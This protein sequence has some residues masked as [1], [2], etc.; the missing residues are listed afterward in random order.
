MFHCRDDDE[1][2]CHKAVIS[3]C[4]KNRRRTAVGSRD[5]EINEM[6]R[7]N[8]VVPLNA[9]AR[10]GVLTALVFVPSMHRRLTS[11]KTKQLIAQGESLLQRAHQLAVQ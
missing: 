8:R 6:E 1:Q 7:S 4:H 3:P 2:P 11:S 5:D 9:F 10:C